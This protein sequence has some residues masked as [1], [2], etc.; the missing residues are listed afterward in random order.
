MLI[1][2]IGMAIGI[3]IGWNWA[4]PQPVKDLQDRLVSFVRS[5]TNKPDR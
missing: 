5:L 2:V 4:Q 3:L 1:L